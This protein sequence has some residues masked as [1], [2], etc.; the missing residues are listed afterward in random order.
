M[1][2]RKVKVQRKSV[3]LRDVGGAFL[4]LLFFGIPIGSV[5]D[6]LWNL[7]VLSVALPLLPGDPVKVDKWRRIAFC[8]FITVLGLIIDLAYFEL[9]WDAVFGKTAV[10]DPAMAQWLQ[11]LWLLLPMSMI[12]L[13]NAAIS[14]SFFKLDRRQAIVFGAIMGFFTAPWL[15]PIMPYILERVI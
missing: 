14:Y 5:L 7:F 10:W 3:V 9:T 6:F 13:V 12:F 1:T 11:F 8:F 2:D 15:L 4:L